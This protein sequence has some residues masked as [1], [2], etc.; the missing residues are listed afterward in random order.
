MKYLIE[1]RYN[2]WIAW[3]IAVVMIIAF[4]ANKEIKENKK[5]NTTELIC[6]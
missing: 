1:S 3:T 5:E 6:Y 2:F 4:R